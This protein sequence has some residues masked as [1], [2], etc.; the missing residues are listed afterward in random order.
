MQ[1]EEVTFLKASS[2]GWTVMPD[3]SVVVSR[4]RQS[5]GRV[6]SPQR[7]TATGAPVYDLATAETL[8][9]GARPP[10]RPAAIRPWWI[11]SGWTVLTVAPKPFAPQSLGGAIAAS[12]DGRIRTF[13]P[14]C[15]PRTN[16]LRPI[17]R[18]S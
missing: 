5:R 2:G 1:P 17:G 16:R 9:E 12:R 6:M 11:P 13:G 15:T 10:R 4:R 18:A 7:F 3:L 8:V 14:G